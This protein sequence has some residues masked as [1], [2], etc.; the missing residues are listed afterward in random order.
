MPRPRLKV[1]IGF[2]DFLRATSAERLAPISLPM[3]PRIA[4]T[5]GGSSK[6]RTAN[7]LNEPFFVAKRSLILL[8]DS[9]GEVSGIRRNSRSASKITRSS[10]LSPLTVLPTFSFTFAVTWA[11]LPGPIS[12]EYIF[13]GTSSVIVGETCVVRPNPLYAAR[14]LG[15]H[16]MPL[17]LNTAAITSLGSGFSS[18][19]RDFLGE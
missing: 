6:A 1:V 7:R 15:F 14:P 5:R 4:R 16:S 11:L 2:R 13:L 19:K 17:L 9:A 8:T 12:S 10:S 3:A 18:P